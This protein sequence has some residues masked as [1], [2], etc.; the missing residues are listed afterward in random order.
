MRVLT[1]TYPHLSSKHA[2]SDYR[3]QQVEQ[4]VE[5][6]PGQMLEEAVVKDLCEMTG[7]W[8]VVIKRNVEK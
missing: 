4:S 2:G 8:K 1:L 3:V 5:Y 6:K 7:M